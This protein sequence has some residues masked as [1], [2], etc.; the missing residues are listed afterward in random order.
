MKTKV[1]KTGTMLTVAL[2]MSFS[3]PIFSQ[4]RNMSAEKALAWVEKNG[5]KVAQMNRADVLSI[6][7]V[8]LQLAISSKLT[9]AQKHTFMVEHL[10]EV[11]MFD[12][13]EEEQKH[14]KEL[15][16]VIAQSPSLFEC[17]NAA[18]LENALLMWG[19]RGVEK[20][21]WT[22]YTPLSIFAS[23]V[24]MLDKTGNPNLVHSTIEIGLAL[25][26]ANAE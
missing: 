10:D 15:Y 26:R 5:E 16:Y 11:L 2:L 3:L 20:F 7:D 13:S 6:S 19:T 8:M 21:G 25:G 24:N 22:M 17:S 18:T 14:L 1:F 9:P 23:S 12:W 4:N